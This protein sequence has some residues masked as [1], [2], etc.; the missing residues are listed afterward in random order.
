MRMRR[1]G[2]SR[3]PRSQAWQ[4]ARGR[5]TMILRASPSV[6]VRV[7]SRSPDDDG[8]A[9]PMRV[10]IGHDTH[11][12]VE[13][14]PL[15]LGGVRIDHPRGLLGH[16]DADVVLHAV[17][18]AL[19]GAAAPGRH[20]RAFPRH[21]PEVEGARRR[22]APGRGGRAGRPGGLDRRQLRR[23][24]STPR[25]RSSRPHKPAIRDN[26]AR[27]LRVDPV[28][29]QR[30]GQDRRARRPDRP[31]RGDR[32]RGGRPPR[33]RGLEDSGLRTSVGLRSS[34]ALRGS[35]SRHPITAIDARLDARP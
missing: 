32:L 3:P 28:R 27:L 14:R 24:R 23:G 16:S 5:D 6:G 29:R 11:R 18:D 26:L 25:S 9:S 13:G 17:A 8:G 22:P 31:G 1:N 30:E 33:S 15:I 35:P 2:N 20:R 4:N 34:L 12:L 7:Q 21:R 10:G 19:L